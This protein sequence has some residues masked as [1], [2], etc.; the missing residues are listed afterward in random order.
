VSNRTLAIDGLIAVL[1]AALVLIISP[2]LAVSGMIAL[3]VLLILA[4]SFALQSRRHHR[5]ARVSAR[6]RR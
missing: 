2:G 3:V 1:I 4:I 6:R 5:R